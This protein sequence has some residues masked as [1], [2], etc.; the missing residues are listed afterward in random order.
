MKSEHEQSISFDN[1]KASKDIDIAP[2][3]FIPFI[4]NAF[5]YSK[6]EEFDKAYVNINL[7]SEKNTLLLEIENSIPESGK[8]LPGNGLG[9]KNVRQRLDLLYPNRYGLDINDDDKKFSVKLKINLS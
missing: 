4:E 8:I 6:V 5:K 3:L 9:I 2:M 1:S 7:S